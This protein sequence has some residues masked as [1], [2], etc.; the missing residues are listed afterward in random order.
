VIHIESGFNLPMKIDINPDGTRAYVTNYLSNDVAVIDI[1]SNSKNRNTVIDHIPVGIN[2]IGIAV[3]PDGLQVLVANF[4]SNDISIIDVDLNSGAYNQVVAN[5]RTENGNRDVDITPDGTL[6]VITSG[7]DLLII[8]LDPYDLEYDL[9]EIVVRN[10]G[11]EK[12]REVDITPD[13]TLAFVTTESGD[14]QVFDIFLPSAYFGKVVANKATERRSRDL[15][16]NPDG[17]LLY[18]TN[19]EDDVVSVY[20]IGYVY[21]GSYMG[22][23]APYQQVVVTEITLTLVQTIP[24]GDY[25]SGIAIDPVGRKVIVVNTQSQDITIIDMYEAEAASPVESIQQLQADVIGLYEADGM[26]LANR[27]LLINDLDV[28]IE[29]IEGGYRLLAIARIKAFI[30]K[31]G[32]YIRRGTIDEQ[33][34]QVL[35]DSANDIITQIN[36]YMSKQLADELISHSII[37]DRFA[38]NQNFP[39]PFNPITTITYDIPG[40]ATEGVHVKLVVYNILGQVVKTLVDEHKQPG[41]YNIRWDS[42]SSDNIPLASGIYIYR[43]EAGDFVQVRKMVLIR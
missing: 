8:N 9:Y 12:R 26:T 14:I 29:R 35:I 11:N 22:V 16:I 32:R 1:D 28:A 13:G 36:E 3:T 27:I 5:R 15:K 7:Y 4:S 39:N 25:P 38:L 41:R 34:G 21:G 33:D 18:V 6:A 19:S 10:S 20:E 40:S 17:T 37:P 42:D 2:P 30:R 24:V 31:V 23:T 43:I